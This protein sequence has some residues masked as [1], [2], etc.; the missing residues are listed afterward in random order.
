VKKKKSTKL[1]PHGDYC[2]TPVKVVMSKKRGPVQKVRPCP[3]WSIR[4][5]KPSQM[6]GYCSYLNE[7]D[8][9]KKSQGLLWDQVKSCGINKYTDEELEK[10]CDEIF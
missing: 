7:G 6:N 8:W 10:I 5:G 1:I 3:Y 2:Y 4:D 9:H